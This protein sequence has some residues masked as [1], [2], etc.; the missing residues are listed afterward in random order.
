MQLHRL[1]RT[2]QGLQPLPAL[3]RPAWSC[4]W[5]LC[6][7]VLLVLEMVLEPGCVGA[8]A[9]AT[10]ARAGA[11]A[12]ARTWW[13]NYRQHQHQRGEGQMNTSAFDRLLFKERT[14]G[15]DV[16]GEFPHLWFQPTSERRNFKG[17]LF[18]HCNALPGKYIQRV[19]GASSFLL[20]CCPR[21]I[22]DSL[23]R[24]EFRHIWVWGIFE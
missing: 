8:D 3:P 10:C 23:W 19:T 11:R 9:R 2:P 1:Q 7:V 16:G 14:L 17:I 24:G 12:C 21:S 5:C 15:S 22:F 6:L 18:L 20:H 4:C 13:P